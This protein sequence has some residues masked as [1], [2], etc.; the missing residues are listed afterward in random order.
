MPSSHGTHT[1]ANTY[2][3]IY[4]NTLT[5]TYTVSV[6]VACIHT[7]MYIERACTCDE[8]QA[9]SHVSTYDYTR[10]EVIETFLVVRTNIPVGRPA[11][12]DLRLKS[13]S[14]IPTRAS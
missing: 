2:V 6:V 11:L 9:T 14:Q 5:R 7:Y 12:E 3:Y 1:H 8:D 4:T 13:Q 10:A